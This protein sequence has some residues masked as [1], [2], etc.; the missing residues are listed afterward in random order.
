[1][2]HQ[3]PED[4]PQ[5]EEMPFAIVLGE[6]VVTLPKDLYIPP[7]ALEVILDAFEG[8]LDLLLYLIKRRNLDILD[9]PIAEIT[10]QY[11]EYVELM[12]GLRLELA[13]DYLVMAA[14]LAEIK[15][16]MLLP[17][18]EA[19]SEEEED[20]RAELVRR[21]Q[22]YERYKQAAE[23]IDALPR[24]NRDVFQAGADFPDRLVEHHPPD[25]TLQE[26]L[27]SL[28]DVLR[29]AEMLTHHRVERESLSM[30]ER[31]SRVLASISTGGFTEFTSL[32]DFREGRIGVVVTF[33][34]VLELIKESLI[35][36]VQAEPYGPIHIKAADDVSEGD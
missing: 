15:S 17:R 26:M 14:M 34:A 16:R 9:I 5:Q 32:F 19:D 6:P 30:R 33:L 29:R 35:E 27:I 24:L 20:P 23:D 11:M 3:H 21:L 13:A 2:I 18:S 28:H 36:L 1:M 7:D 25:V 22:E 10:R 8:P 31:M 4:H 12:K